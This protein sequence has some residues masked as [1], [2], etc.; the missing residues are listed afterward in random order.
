M[1]AILHFLK[2]IFE[3]M[4]ILPTIAFSIILIFQRV[5]RSADAK[6]GIYGGKDEFL[7][8]GTFEERVKMSVKR[9]SEFWRTEV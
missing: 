6:V 7:R 5:V 8:Q 1:S 4:T 3:K 2:E 9:S